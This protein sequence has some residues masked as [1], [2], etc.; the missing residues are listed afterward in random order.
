MNK[1]NLLLSALTIVF[2]N[3]LLSSEPLNLTQ[4]SNHCYHLYQL[5]RFLATASTCES[6]R[7][8]TEKEKIACERVFEVMR[9][10]MEKSFPKVEV[11]NSCNK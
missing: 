10:K 7:R 6:Q 3:A 4:A 8:M 9:Q 2:S 1:K 11:K 5:H